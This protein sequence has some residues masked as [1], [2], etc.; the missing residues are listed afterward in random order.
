ML[1]RW[2]PPRGDDFI[3]RDTSPTEMVAKARCG[4]DAL[5]AASST[6]LGEQKSGRH[7]HQMARHT[8]QPGRAPALA[9]RFAMSALA[10]LLRCDC[11]RQHT[12]SAH[13]IRGS[14]AIIFD[15]FAH[16][17]ARRIG[18]TASGPTGRSDA[19][20]LV[21]MPSFDVASAISRAPRARSAA[22]RRLYYAPVRA[23]QAA[24]GRAARRARQASGRR[25]PSSYSKSMILRQGATAPHFLICA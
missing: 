8:I 25:T 23:F 22:P 21:M 1:S 14:A 7:H 12:R 11:A 5:R 6:R 20:A 16:M 18:F 17:M 9:R 19:E 10:A 13:A 15:D 2:P 4:C 24:D 3:V